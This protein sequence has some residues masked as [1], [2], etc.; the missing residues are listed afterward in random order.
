VSARAGSLLAAA[1]A[2]LPGS[3]V[4]SQEIE[5]RLVFDWDLISL[6]QNSQRFNGSVL[7]GFHNLRSPGVTPARAWRPG[8]G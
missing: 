3:A 7:S 6:E 8:W 2:L 1:L 4:L 5:G